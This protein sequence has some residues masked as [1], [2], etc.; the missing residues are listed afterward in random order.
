VKKIIRILV[1]V[2]LVAGLV[3]GGVSLIKQQKDY[4]QGEK[5]YADAKDLVGISLEAPEQTPEE[6]PEEVP[7]EEAEPEEE[8]KPVDPQL[9]T[10]L[11]LNLDNLRQVNPEVIGWID[12]PGTVISYPVMQT[13]NNTKYLS[14]TWKQEYSSVGSIYMESTNRADLSQFNTILYGHNMQDGSMFCGLKD[15]QDQAYWEEHPY[16]YLAVDGLARKYAIYTAYEVRTWEITYGLEID[17]NKRKQEFID[18]GLGE[19]DIDTGIVPTVEDTI[20]TLST[21][22]GL[23]NGRRWVVQAVCVEEL[24]G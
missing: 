19:S 20:L 24:T 17:S 13:T 11:G 1:A 10:M 12:I 16:I 7:V 21:C 5:D 14:L 2:V 3:V 15:F 4:K 18:F 9:Q 8:V 23:G 6:A 22:T